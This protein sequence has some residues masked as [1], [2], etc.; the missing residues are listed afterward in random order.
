VDQRRDSSESCG[1]VE[2]CKS[3]QRTARCPLARRLLRHWYNQLGERRTEEWRAS[4]H[5]VNGMKQDLCLW[6]SLETRLA[7][8]SRMTQ[9]QTIDIWL[10]WRRSMAA[11][12]V[13]AVWS[14]QVRAS[15]RSCYEVIS[16]VENRAID[17]FSRNLGNAYP[18]ATTVI[19]TRTQ[20]EIKIC[21]MILGF[22]FTACIQRRA[23][24]ANRNVNIVRLCGRLRSR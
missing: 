17:E 20:K 16:S 18:I 23:R 13:R 4:S 12:V 9:A 19:T 22:R 10:H 11:L 14:E 21:L 6:W 2:I 7:K 5:C 15:T 24:D 3:D 1:C 8:V